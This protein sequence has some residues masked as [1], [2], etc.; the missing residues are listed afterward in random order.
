MDSKFPFKIEAY[1]NQDLPPLLHIIPGQNFGELLPSKR[2]LSQ[3]RKTSKII[4][5]EN[6]LFENGLV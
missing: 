2:M 3:D 1:L 5:Q 6:P 4:I